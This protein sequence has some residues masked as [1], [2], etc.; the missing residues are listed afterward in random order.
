MAGMGDLLWEPTEKLKAEANLTHFMKWMA[1]RGESFATYEELRQ[2]SITDIEGFWQAVWDY[3]DVQSD[4][5]YESVLCGGAMLGA[6]WFPGARV[7]Y[8]RHILS[9]GDGEKIAIHAAGET[10]PVSTLSWGELKSR[11]FKLATRMRELGI[12]PGDRVASYMPN[13]PEAVIAFFA[14]ASIG[15]VWSSCSPDFGSASVIDR[16]SQ[17]TPKLLFTVAGYQYG[18][19]YFDRSD[20]VRA[21]IDALPSLDHVVHVSSADLKPSPHGAPV[22]HLWDDLFSGPEVIES[23]FQFE[24]TAFDHPLWIV[25]SSGTTGLPKPFVHGHGGILLEALKFTHF[26]LNLKPTSCMFYFT[27]TGWVMWN[28]LLSGLVAG[29]AVVLYD[30]N[31][32]VPEPDRLWRVAQDTGMTLFGASPTWLGQQMKLGITPN[33]SFN[34]TRMESILLGG[35]PVMPEH[36][37]WCYENIDPA[38]WVT[39]QSGGTDVASAF[40]GGVPLL[41]GYAGEIQARLLGVDAVA[42]DDDGHEIV[43]HVGELVVRKPMPSMPL[44]FWND[45]DGKRYFESYFDSYPGVWQHGDYFKVNAH[46]GCFIL[47]RSD[48]TL[49]RYGVRIGTA[50]IYRTIEALPDIQDSIIVNLD[51]PGGTFFMPLFVV[52][53]EGATLNE[54][55]KGEIKKSL[56]EKYSPRHV[57]DE[58]YQIAA[59]PYTL[60]GKKMEVP[61]RKI[62][63]GAEVDKAASRDAM[64]NPHAIAYFVEFANTQTK[65]RMTRAV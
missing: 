16:F 4:T 13:I 64:S 38:I 22:S 19:K 44:Y 43:D 59:V 42:F 18:G 30:G 23:A 20:E 58:I 50:E 11:V 27:T 1:D 17:I 56:R 62:L 65:Y 14:S 49:N 5:P 12:R 40:V 26:H 45:A 37:V 46:G 24:N 25:Y 21:M 48:S 52:L 6:Q 9:K 54:E 7:N 39:S 2:W 57:P 53:R 3:F 60:T 63:L 47:G 32:M 36:M 55:I 29:S 31:P 28:I 33:K 41:P 51:L 8:I 34:L 35:S 10:G 61:V 15:A